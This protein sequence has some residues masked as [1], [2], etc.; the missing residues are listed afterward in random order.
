MAE[1]A[2]EKREEQQKNNVVEFKREFTAF[3]NDAGEV[4]AFAPKGKTR[5]SWGVNWIVCYQEAMK[6]LARENLPNQ[7]Y[8]VLM[9]LLGELDF[10]NFIRIRQAGI[11]EAL[12]MK[13]S[14]IS[15][16]IRGLL[17][18]NILVA[19]PQMGTAKTYRLN[20]RMAYK[21]KDP[22]KTIVEYEDLKR[23]REQG[24]EQAGED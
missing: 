10:E 23:R 21:G 1:S 8:R 15:R 11:G 14:A 3:T 24:Q 17:G 6:W 22:T 13:P 7:E 4:E 20:P 16:A 19:G 12:G 5:N 18:R 2:E 9:F